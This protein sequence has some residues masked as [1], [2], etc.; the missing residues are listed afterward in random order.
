MNAPLHLAEIPDRAPGI[1]DLEPMLER[2]ATLAD[3][4]SRLVETELGRKH[5][6]AELGELLNIIGETV[7]D[8]EALRQ[9]LSECAD[10]SGVRERWRGFGAEKEMR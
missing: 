2:I 1:G 7:R 3:I 5:P 6:A 4:A 10:G 9:R 8:A